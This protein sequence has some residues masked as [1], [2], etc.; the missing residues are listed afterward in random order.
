MNPHQVNILLVIYYE[1]LKKYFHFF[2]LFFFEKSIIM[3][4]ECNVFCQMTHAAKDKLI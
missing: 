2:F 4:G 3:Y 1:T